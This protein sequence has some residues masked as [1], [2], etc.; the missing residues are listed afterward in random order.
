MKFAKLSLAAVAAIGF[1]TGAMALDLSK[2]TIKPYVNTKLYY[3]TVDANGQNDGSAYSKLFNQNSSEGQALAQVGA[4]GNLNGC[5]GYGL[6]YSVADT[7]G[8]ENDVVRQTRMGQNKNSNSVTETQDWMS[9]AYITFKGCGTPLANTTFKIGRQYLDTPLAFT[10]TW[11]LAPN[12]FDAIVVANT[13]IPNVTLVGASVGKGNG[14]FARVANGDNFQSYGL[15]GGAL[16]LGALTNFGLPVNVWYYNV[17]SAANPADAYDKGVKAWW[18]DTNYKTAYNGVK[19]NMGAQYGDINPNADGVKDTKGGAIKLGA[20]F[21]DFTLSGAYSK[22]KDDG[23][24]G[25]ANT[26]T[27][28]KYNGGANGAGGKKT[29]LYTAGIYTDGTAVAMPGSKAYKIAG[30]VNTSYGKFTLAYVDCKNDSATNVNLRNANTNVKET[31]L[32]YSTKVLGINTKLIYI[33]RNVD[34]KYENNTDEAVTAAQNVGAVLD[35][36]TK[37]VRIVL[38]KNF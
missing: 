32:I 13:D 22:M 26:A 16:A 34:S 36:D 4:T 11:N 20:A 14:T 27:I 37:H 9:Q 6:E 25:L 30:S 12:S 10:E 18:I 19:Y 21:G 7:L 15:G 17:K 38:S 28:T 35:H 5:W 33:D 29:K 23:L 3:E 8:L 2:A 1:S 31:D 24:V